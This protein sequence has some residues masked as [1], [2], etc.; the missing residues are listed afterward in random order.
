MKLA[1]VAVM[2]GCAPAARAITGEELC[3]GMDWPMPLPPTVGYG[4]DHTM[5][6]S[7]LVCFDNMV[8]TAP[9]GHN[10]MN[11]TIDKSPRLLEGD[12]H[13]PPAGTLV[14]RDKDFVERGP[15]RQPVVVKPRWPTQLTHTTG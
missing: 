3:K 9:D 6:D 1:A 14:D 10:V 8:A 13:V 4:I 2:I 12:Q 5:N 15:R 7:V 11:D